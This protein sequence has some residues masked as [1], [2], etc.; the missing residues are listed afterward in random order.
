VE[1]SA[2]NTIVTNQINHARLRMTQNT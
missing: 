2:T 1:G